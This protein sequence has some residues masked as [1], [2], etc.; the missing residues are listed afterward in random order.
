[1]LTGR[2]ATPRTTL[3]HLVV[4]SAQLITAREACSISPPQAQ[5]PFAKLWICGLQDVSALFMED[6]I[7]PRYTSGQHAVPFLVAIIPPVCPLPSPGFVLSFS[8]SRSPLTRTD[9]RGHAVHEFQAR[10]PPGR[11]AATREVHGY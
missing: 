1:M 3:D 2:G 4:C 10:R 9:K 8:R 5:L 7:A 11:L 6:M